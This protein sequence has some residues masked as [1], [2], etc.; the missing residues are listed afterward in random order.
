MPAYSRLLLLSSAVL[1][2][3]CAGSPSPATTAAAAAAQAPTQQQVLLVSLDGF[4]WDYFNRPAAR[5][6]RRLAAEGVHAERMVP[7]YPSV[8]FPNH[9]TIVTGLYPDHHGNI[10]NTIR[11]SVLGL[12]RIS[13]STAV[14]NARWWGGEPLWV[15]AE[16]QGQHAASFFWPGSEAAVEGVRPSR[17]MPFNDGFPNAAR[18]DS[19]LSWLTLPGAQRMSL[20]TLYYSDVDHAGHAYGPASPQVDSAIAR[21]DSMVGLLMDGIAARGLSNRVNLMVVADHGMAELSPDK[22]ILLDDYVPLGDV[23]IVD[24]GALGLIA[25]KQGKTESV[26]AALHDANPHM[27]VYRKA[28]V[29]ARFHYGTNPRI[30]AIVA[31]PDEGYTIT[32]RARAGS[33]ATGGNHGYDNRLPDMGALFVAEG[34]AF[35]RGVTVPPFQNIHVYDLVCRILGLTPA[36]NDGSPDST[37]ALLRP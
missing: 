18:V 35:R 2:L 31:I 11:D 10:A 7:S 4:R 30:P 24:G 3:G 37:R 26:Y 8:T 33:G 32:T 36:P 15:T 22:T 21:V 23:D 14:R 25:P 12:F 27:H 20:V 1:T 17:S 16:T 29:P 5:N 9:Y 34:P 6:I 19:V 28:D 13:D